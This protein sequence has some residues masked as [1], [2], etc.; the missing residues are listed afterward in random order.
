[1][2]ENPHIKALQIDL[3]M[4]LADQDGKRGPRTNAA[5]LAAADA[6]RL[7]VTKPLVIIKAPDAPAVA[8]VSVEADPQLKLVH[9]RLVDVVI[10]AS[11]RCP[12]P[13]DV[14]EG[15]RTQERQAQLVKIGASKTHD[16]R[17]L[18]GH[19]VDLWPKDPKT[20]KNL[21]SD[22]AFPKG[23]AEAKEANRRL[24]A[25][26]RI[27]AA[28]MKAVAK[29]KGVQLEWGGDWGWDAPHFQLNR[30]AYPA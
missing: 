8:Q 23:S 5:I 10:E 14:I 20:N 13:F 28:T 26:L 29:E 30:A 18:T 22:A 25:D 1:M 4:S 9:V 2:K 6:G 16:S 19:A 24:W 17:H 3:G 27:I 12:I 11:K 7:Q 21:P 15:R